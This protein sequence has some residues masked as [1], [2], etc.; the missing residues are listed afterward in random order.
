MDRATIS[1]V[2]TII[3][4]VQGAY[5]KDGTVTGGAVSNVLNN[6]LK[7]INQTESQ[8]AEIEAKDINELESYAGPMDCEESLGAGL[9]GATAVTRLVTVDGQSGGPGVPHLK[10]CKIHFQEALWSLIAQYNT[11]QVLRM[12]AD[13]D[14]LPIIVVVIPAYVEPVTCHHEHNTP[15]G[16]SLPGCTHNCRDLTRGEDWDSSM[17]PCS[18]EGACLIC[19][20]PQPRREFPSRRP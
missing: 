9:C 19:H 6:I 11:L 18:C 8:A 1:I 14:G 13:K 3:R 2:E 5:V 7:E 15:E 20:Y 17:P 10:A 16:D 4:R 12:G